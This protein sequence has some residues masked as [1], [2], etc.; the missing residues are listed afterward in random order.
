MTLDILALVAGL[1]FALLGWRS[2][3]VSQCM[4]LVAAIAAFAAASPVSRLAQDILFPNTDLSGPVVEALLLVGA[5]VGVYIVLALA[6]WL[7]ARAMWAASDSLT[8]LDRTGGLG[9]GLL[10]AIVLVYFLV[11]VVAMA[12]AP[13]RE[14]DERDALHLRDGYVLTWVERYNVLVPWRFGDLGRLHDALAVRAALDEGKAGPVVR[15]HPRAADFL[16]SPAIKKMGDDD[17][18]VEAA[19]NDAYHRTLADGRVR[20]YL[21]DDEFVGRL[22]M[23]DWEAMVARVRGEAGVASNTTN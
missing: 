14:I 4:R 1:I 8:I 7:F 20:K 12:K 16:R 22:R 11:A 9:L 13:L 23:V 2:G 3:A 17:E 21:N 15:R 10:K 6:G 18:L 19:K 5:G